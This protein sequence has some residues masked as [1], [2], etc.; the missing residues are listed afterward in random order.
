MSHRHIETTLSRGISLIAASD[1]K[2]YLQQRL[3][4]YQHEVFACMFLD[5]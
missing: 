3:R 2:R 5:N 4:H 1:T